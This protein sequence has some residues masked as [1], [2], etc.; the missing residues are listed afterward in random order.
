MGRSEPVAHVA[1]AGMWGAP[2]AFPQHC[3]PR[4]ALSPGALSSSLPGG[5]ARAWAGKEGAGEGWGGGR[6]ARGGGRR[7]RK[8]R[9]GR[10][11]LGRG[12]AVWPGLVS[13][14]FAPL[15]PP[16]LCGSK[17]VRE[18]RYTRRSLPEGGAR[19]AL[20][21]AGDRR[22]RRELA[23]GSASSRDAKFLLW[24]AVAARRARR[25]GEQKRVG[26]AGRT[27]PPP[28]AQP[29]G[30]V[31]GGSGGLPGL[32]GRRPLEPACTRGPLPCPALRPAFSPPR[33][34]S[35]SEG[36]CPPRFRFLSSL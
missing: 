7:G 1:P 24:E 26:G 29:V 8:R 31:G 22:G 25:L 28:A 14:G 4:W 15:Q 30:G 36:R 19:L 12:P 9:A 35:Q 10:P 16:T 5:A 3:C 6:K 13:P 32:G 34:T 20:I 33:A 17:G 11:E 2:S 27:G 18:P 23:R 21:G